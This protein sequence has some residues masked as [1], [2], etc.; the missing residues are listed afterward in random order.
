MSIEHIFTINFVLI[1]ICIGSFLNVVIYRTPLYKKDFTLNTPRSH[2]PV[3]KNQLAWYENI[4]VIAWIILRG[5]CKH[6]KVKIPF[7]YPLIELLTGFFI[8]SP[9]LLFGMTFNTVMAGLFAGLSI[10]VCWW[11]LNKQT[12]NNAMRYWALLPLT[13]FTLM[14]IKYAIN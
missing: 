4:P 5:K 14:V 7:K 9:V 11:L 8:S 6:C 1:S 3:C 13:C 2:C 10:P 12:F